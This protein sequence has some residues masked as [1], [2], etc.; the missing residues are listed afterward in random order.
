MAP[1]RQSQRDWPADRTVTIK[2]PAGTSNLKLIMACTGA[3]AGRLQVSR[4][5]HGSPTGLLGFCEPL[6]PGQPPPVQATVVR[7]DGKAVTLTLRLQPP[8]VYKAA[9]YYKR[10]ASWT[11]ALYAEQKYPTGK[12]PAPPVRGPAPGSVKTLSSW[13]NSPRSG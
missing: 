12:T 3:T 2:V 9:D 11:I 7:P 1:G 6:T 10:A 5:S 13:L 8:D 4:T